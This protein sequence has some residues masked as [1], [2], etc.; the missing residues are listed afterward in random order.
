M[1]DLAIVNLN[2]RLSNIEK[3]KLGNS[4]K[5]RKTIPLKVVNNFAVIT[6]KMYLVFVK[7]QR[8]TYNK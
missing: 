7:T 5:H 8:I 3:T 6:L 2:K 4:I 1:P